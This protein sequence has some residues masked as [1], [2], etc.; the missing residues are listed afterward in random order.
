LACESA[1]RAS[2]PSGTAL[3]VLDARCCA[4]KYR[5]KQSTFAKFA[6]S[7]A[8][9]TIRTMALSCAMRSGAIPSQESREMFLTAVN[10]WAWTPA[11]AL[12]GRSPQRFAGSPAGA[13]RP[14][15]LRSALNARDCRPSCRRARAGRYC[16]GAWWFSARCWRRPSRLYRIQDASA[17]GAS[18]SRNRNGAYFAS[19]VVSV[20]SLASST[21]T[22]SSFA[23][24]VALA[25]SLTR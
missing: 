23:G 10:N 19:G 16:W 18:R 11:G 13:G 2:L 8:T 17:G 24:S 3:H 20:V 22:A 21:N 7:S 14:K 6:T 12:L 25:F 1:E 5:Y 4:Q 9:A 15:S